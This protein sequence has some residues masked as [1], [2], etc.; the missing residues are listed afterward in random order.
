MKPPTTAFLAALLLLF[1]GSLA[2]P[3]PGGGFHS[4]DPDHVSELDGGFQANDLTKPLFLT[5]DEMQRVTFYLKKRLVFEPDG[6]NC[7]KRDCEKG[8]F[9]AC[10][11]CWHVETPREAW[12]REYRY[13]DD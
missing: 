3:T 10:R 2:A 11:F 8:F 12:V 1:P 9:D 6:K 13:G 5:V 4:P 7:P